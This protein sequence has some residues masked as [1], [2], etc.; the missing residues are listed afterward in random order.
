MGEEPTALFTLRT[1]Q[2][3]DHA[4]QISFAGGKID[5]VDTSPAAAAL[6]SAGSS[7]TPTSAWP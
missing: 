1:T 4:G 3:I 2:L 6:A 7:A 5:S